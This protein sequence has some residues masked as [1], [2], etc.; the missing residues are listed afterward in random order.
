MENLNWLEVSCYY[1]EHFSLLISE[2]GPS[3]VAKCILTYF[4]KFSW[5]SHGIFKFSF[6]FKLKM[7]KSLNK[8][9]TNYLR[10][11]RHCTSSFRSMSPRSGRDMDHWLRQSSNIITLRTVLRICCKISGC[12]SRTCRNMLLGVGT[13][14]RDFFPVKTINI[15]HYTLVIQRHMTEMKVFYSLSDTEFHQTII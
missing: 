4:I 10:V 9:D 5:Y 3:D 12:S 8:Y 7:Y 13:P 6:S 14:L 2:K 11:L 15:Q 1:G